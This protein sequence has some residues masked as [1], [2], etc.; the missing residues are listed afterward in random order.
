MP[1]LFINATN[2]HHGGG[3]VLL[4]ALLRSVPPVDEVVVQVDARMCLPEDTPKNIRFLSIKPTLSARLAAE[5]RLNRMTSTNDRI[6]CF[7]N[8]PPLFR[9]RGRISVF[10]QNRYLVDYGAPLS[11]FSPKMKLKLW[12]ERAW[13]YWFRF[14]ASDYIVQTPSMRKLTEDRLGVPVVCVP[15]IPSAVEGLRTRGERKFDFLYVASGEP[16]K[17]HSL[18]LDAWILLAQEGVF[19]SLA[20]T[21]SLDS[22][23]ELCA[24]ISQAVDRHGLSI[25]NLGVLQHNRLQDVYS[26]SG[27][28]IYPS[29]F[30]SFGLPL[31]EACQNNLPVLASEL[32][33]VR[34][35]LDPDETFDPSSA[36]SIARAVKR[37]LGVRQ[38]P[39]EVSHARAFYERVWGE[40]LY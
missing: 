15:F 20:L 13:L 34:D 7:G 24:R 3:S 25:Q 37:F 5:I 36:V 1:R 8:L 11:A 31:A 33:F 29:K 30:E 4:R 9:T 26:M 35:I 6:L 21:I 16:H 28:L 22:A 14:N 27:A 23:P 17:N 18:L 32:D 10:L 38:P 12:L 2:I 39:L 40:E 19:P